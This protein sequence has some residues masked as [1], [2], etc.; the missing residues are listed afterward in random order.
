MIP[1]ES[2][3]MPLILPALSYDNICEILPTGEAHQR[4]CPVFMGAGHVGII[5]LAR[6]R[7]LDCQSESTCSSWTTLFSQ[8]GTMRHSYQGMV[9]TLPKSTFPEA[10]QGPVLPVGLSK[11]SSLISVVLTGFCTHAIE[12]EWLWVKF[13]IIVTALEE[14]DKFVP[15]LW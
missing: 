15:V 5:C 8:T 7:I 2:H 10:S 3:G 6:T 9:G 14:D 12:L 11:D 13:V 1:L 4:Q